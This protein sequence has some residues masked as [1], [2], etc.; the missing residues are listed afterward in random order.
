MADTKRYG[1]KYRILR[2]AATHAWDVLS[3][4]TSA[5]DV[6]MEDGSS[7]QTSF[8][9]LAQETSASTAITDGLQTDVSNAPIY[10]STKKYKKGDIVK[11][12]GSFYYCT[13]DID[14]PEAW[15]SSHW[16]VVEDKIPFRFGIDSDGNYGYIKVGADSVIPFKSSVQNKILLAENVSGS[17]TISA[18]LINQIC[19]EN[20]INANKLSVNNFVMEMN[21]FVRS[22]LWSRLTG[23]DAS[24]TL[25]QPSLTLSNGALNYNTGAW[26]NGDWNATVWI[27]GSR[28]GYEFDIDVQRPDSNNWVRAYESHESG[29]IN[30]TVTITVDIAAKCNIYLIA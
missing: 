1:R 9:S 13:V 21:G 3:F 5:Q 7:L 26:R 10:D 19:T 27:H 29:S 16:H 20:R 18:E 25:A 4:W 8:A 24:Q 28:G 11:Y 22:A 15:N 6:E 2:D 17:G 23:T 14:V 30:E 12:N